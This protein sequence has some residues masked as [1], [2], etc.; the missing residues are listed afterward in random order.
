MILLVLF[1]FAFFHAT[2]SDQPNIILNDL[3][4][5]INNHSLTDRFFDGQGRTY[6]IN[7]PLTFPNQTQFLKLTNFRIIVEGDIEAF[8]ATPGNVSFMFCEFSRIYIT[9]KDHSTEGRKVWD[10][11]NFAN[12]LFKQIWIT[13]VQN[14]TICFYGEGRGGHTPYYNI[15]DQVYLGGLKYGFHFNDSGTSA[16]GPNSNTITDSRIQPGIGGIGVLVGRQSQM[17]RIFNTGIESPGGIGV[18]SYG[19]ST[20]V[21]ACRFEGLEIGFKIMSTA[22]QN[23]LGFC[24][25]S[26]I[27]TSRWEDH[28]STQP[29]IFQDHV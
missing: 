19:Y 9:C 11:S 10:F 2:C 1:C 27:L 6:A 12:S 20:M 14:K 29:F 4:S 16:S 7:E 17:T 15:F 21:N 26:S 25:Y 8:S 5:E 28:N 18:Q 3:Q 23:Y 13:G 24:Y 22:N